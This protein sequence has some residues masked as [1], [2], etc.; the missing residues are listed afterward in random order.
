MHAANET[1][2]YC[3]QP[4]P[5]DR[6]EEIRARF[7]FK[8]KQDQAA[9]KARYDAQV[10][11]ARTEIEANEAGEIDK[12]K[13]D[14]LLR[15]TLRVGEQGKQVAEAA[16]QRHLATVLAAQEADKKKLQEAEQQRLEAVTQ[17]QTL[18]GQ[19]DTI[20][21]ARVAEARTALGKSNAEANGV[22]DAQHAGPCRSCRAVDGFAAPRRRRGERRRRHPNLSDELQEAVSKR[23]EITRG[24]SKSSDANII[25]VIKQRGKEC[26]K[27]VYDDRNRKIWQDKF[28]TQLRKDMV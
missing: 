3:E 27:I 1:C 24:R 15:R 25:H 23:D 21:T 10:A 13:A 4:I 20:V 5:N 12:L 6:A 17:Y 9:L 22:R 19:T 14:A 2:P 18:K 7:A 28:A 26:G 8:Q 11:A 16:A